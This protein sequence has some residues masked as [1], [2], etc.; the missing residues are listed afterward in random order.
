MVKLSSVN[1]SLVDSFAVLLKTLGVVSTL[2]VGSTKSGPYYHLRLHEDDLGPLTLTHPGRQNSLALLRTT[3]D[4]KT[5]DYSKVVP[6]SRSLSRR[7]VVRAGKSFTSMRE[8]FSAFSSVYSRKGYVSLLV[9][10]ELCEKY[11]GATGDTVLDRWIALVNSDSTCCVVIDKVEV[12]E[13]E[14]V[15]FDVTV[16]GPHLTADPVSGLVT[17]QTM[18][19]HVPSLKEAVE[20][21]KTKLMPS[22]MLFSV[23]SRDATLPAPKHE[24]L[25]GN[26]AA[27]MKPS[28]KVHT[29]ATQEEAL[30]AYDNGL[31]GASDQVIFNNGIPQR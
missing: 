5:R 2:S 3:L 4:D 12:V 6:W 28:G 24:M 13:R 25:L 10:R 14:P 8:S 23:R 27:Q 15:T 1:R 26:F 18:A 29:F 20:D 19:V 21:A 16:P 31:V 30:Q 9:A 7:W 11:P 17:H 22:Q